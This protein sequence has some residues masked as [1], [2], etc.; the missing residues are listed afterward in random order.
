MGEE[1]VRGRPCN[2]IEVS[3]PDGKNTGY[4]KAKLWIDKEIM[5]LLQAEG[6]GM[7]GDL[8]RKLWIESFKKIDDRWM[9]KDMEVQSY[10]S[11]HR[12]KLR[13]NEVNSEE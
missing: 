2:I 3:A 10:P 12:T 13:V 8:K 6:Y 5:M 4:S 1:E 11:V 9:V 7:D